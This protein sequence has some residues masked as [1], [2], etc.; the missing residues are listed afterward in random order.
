MSELAAQSASNFRSLHAPTRTTSERAAPEPNTVSDISK[1]SAQIAGTIYR[2]YKFSFLFPTSHKNIHD[3]ATRTSTHYCTQT[4]TA[5]DHQIY[6][7]YVTIRYLFLSPQEA[8]CEHPSLASSRPPFR[9]DPR[10]DL[11]ADGLS[12]SGEMEAKP[13]TASDI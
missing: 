7:A 5:S 11:A 2:F 8:D 13:N 1:I 4:V 9:T 3:S 12:G 6:C 10:I